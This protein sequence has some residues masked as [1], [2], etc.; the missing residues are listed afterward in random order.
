MV[1]RPK[2]PSIKDIAQAVGLSTAAVSYALSGN[3]RVSIE[4]QENVRRVADAMGFIRNDTA[5]RL[6]TGESNLLGVIVHDISNPFFAEL[7]SDFEAFCYEAGYL[8]IVANT[9]DDL[10]RQATLIDALVAQNVAGLL[11]S[12][13]HTTSRDMMAGLRRRSKPYVICVRDIND[14]SADFVGADDETAGYLAARHLIDTGIVEFG[15]VGG[16]EGS[17]T[18]AGRLQ[19][20]RRALGE[21]GKSIAAEHIIPT[22]PTNEGGETATKRLLE[23][24]PNCCAAICFNDYVAFGAYAALHLAGRLVG[25]NYSIVGFDNLPQS[26]SLLPALTTVDLFPRKIGRHAA[27]TLLE[28]V[29]GVGGEPRRYLVEPRLVARHSVAGA[30]PHPRL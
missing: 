20:I 15:F 11:I 19:G 21:V 12:P 25:V 1:R 4:T 22:S 17:K 7:L 5:A 8:T 27:A 23:T 29:R 28:K 26:S 2:G 30:F 3:G 6:R 14:P 16:H 9:K 13:G 10:V 24:N 18:W